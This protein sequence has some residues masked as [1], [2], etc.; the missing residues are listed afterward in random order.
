MAGSDVNA[1]CCTRSNNATTHPGHIVLQ[2]QQKCCTKAQKATDDKLE[3]EAI[4]LKEAATVAGLKHLAGIQQEMEATEDKAVGHSAKGVRHRPHP[5]KRKQDPTV[6]ID[7]EDVNGQPSATEDIGE[8][9]DLEL[10][11]RDGNA[12]IENRTKEKCTGRKKVV[13]TS[14]KDHQQN[15]KMQVVSH[16]NV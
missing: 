13:K 16:S 8:V 9:D 15:T 11:D 3:R 7:S 4:K 12:E 10:S 14:L 6:C 2:A 1:P 5:V